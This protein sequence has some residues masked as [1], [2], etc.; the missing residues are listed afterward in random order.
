M[1]MG[2]GQGAYDADEAAFARAGLLELQALLF[3]KPAP[4]NKRHYPNEPAYML[5]QNQLMEDGMSDSARK[6][7]AMGRYA[8]AKKAKVGDTIACPGC[9]KHMTKASYQ[10]V[11]CKDKVRG[12]SNCKDFINNW[13]DPTRLMRALD[14]LKAKGKL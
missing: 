12:R 7:L 4:L 8:H 3:S 1:N 13:F 9:G 2:S 11:Y 5:H 14:V 6:E 10:H